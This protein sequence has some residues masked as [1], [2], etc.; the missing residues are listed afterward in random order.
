[1]TS[2]RIEFARQLRKQPTCA[3][4]VFWRCCAARD[5]TAQIPA[6]SPVRSLRRR[7]LC[8]AAKLVIELDGK[9]HQWFSDYD[10]G[11]TEVLQRLG[12][13]ARCPVDERRG[14]CRL[15]FGSGADSTGIEVAL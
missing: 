13:G 1:M 9:Q 7:F 6:A 8:H 10:A 14:L 4:D 3:E 15:R 2:E 11:R 12:M 5:L